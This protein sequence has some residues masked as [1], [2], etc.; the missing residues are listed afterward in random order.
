MNEREFFPAFKDGLD[1]FERSG[2]IKDI[3]QNIAGDLIVKKFVDTKGGGKRVVK[4]ADFSYQITPY[5][6]S[7]DEPEIGSPEFAKNRQEDYR[8][9]KKYLTDFVLKTNYLVAEDEEGQAATFEVQEKIK[10]RTLGQ[11][12]AGE[13]ENYED[14][15]RLFARRSIEMFEEIGWLPDIHEDLSRTDNII[16]DENNQLHFIDNDAI[17]KIP[18][19]ILERYQGNL[20]DENGLNPDLLA[21]LK[22]KGFSSRYADDISQTFNSLLSYK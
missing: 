21:E 22:N 7:E 9:L 4:L 3:Y 18:G 10:G 19:R 12:K 2:A 8:M 17:Y 5:S 20:Y 16:V 14:Q 13:T 6:W 1:R 11:I 15:L